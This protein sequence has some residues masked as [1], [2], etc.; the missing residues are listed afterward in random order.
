[1]LFTL[2]AGTIGSLLLGLIPG[3][4]MMLFVCAG[5]VLL[6][7]GYVGLLI[8]LRNLATEREMKLTFLPR[9]APAHI[10]LG[11]SAAERPRV[12]G[13]SGYALPDGYGAASDMLMRRQAN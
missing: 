3:L 13:D 2:L 8:R 6:F 4:S 12:G 5:F 10:A 11:V 1:M 7:A 9:P